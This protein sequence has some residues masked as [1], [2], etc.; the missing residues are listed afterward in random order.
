MTTTTDQALSVRINGED[1]SIPDGLMIDT[2]LVHLGRDPARSGVAIALNE[3]VVPRSLW[4]ET[5]VY[6][7]DR[8]EIITASQGG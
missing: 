6:D 1:R 4:S 8:I 2:L 3:S 7:T 5:R